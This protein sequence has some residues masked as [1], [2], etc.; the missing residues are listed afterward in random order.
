ME[1]IL[2]DDLDAPLPSA[3]GTGEGVLEADIEDE[4]LDDE[5]LEAKL[6]GFGTLADEDGLEVPLEDRL[7][8]DE[9]IGDELVLELLVLELL[10]L[11]LLVLELLVLELLVLELLVLLV[12]ELLVLELLVLELLVLELLVLELLVA[13]VLLLESDAEEQVPS[14]DEPLV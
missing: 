2:L 9:L 12:L 13:E 8:E 5:L 14:A 7:F 6:T 11:E 4:M 1:K 10:V 3:F